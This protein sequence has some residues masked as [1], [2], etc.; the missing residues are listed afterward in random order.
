[1]S[2]LFSL[3]G[4]NIELSGLSS[5]IDPAA[6][7][8]VLGSHEGES[9]ALL[10]VPHVADQLRDIAG[11]LDAKVERVWPSGLRVTLVARHPV[12]AVASGTGFALLDADAIQVGLVDQAPPELPLVSVPLGDDRVL[13]AVLEVIRNLPP[14]LLGR[15]SG[16]GAQTED[17]VSF[18]LRDGP[19]VEWGSAND[20]ALK[21]QVLAVMIASPSA[22]TAG[23]IDVSAPTLP[24]TRPA[25]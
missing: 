24:I 4:A 8:T 18:V 16:I 15:V 21:A 19:R 25:E 2:P 6:V 5:E 9:L 22:A 11:V 13:A 23:V 20:S 12:A 17:T 14:D 10:N 3:D 7:N 1:M